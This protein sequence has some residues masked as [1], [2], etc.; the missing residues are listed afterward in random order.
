MSTDPQLAHCTICKTTNSPI[1]RRNESD[2]VVCLECYTHKRSDN[3]SLPGSSGGETSSTTT[4]P[5]KK[6]NAKRSKVERVGRSSNSPL[7]N[8]VSKINYRGRRSMSKDIVSV[9]DW[10]RSSNLLICFFF[11]ANKSASTRA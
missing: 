5:R 3:S 10:P 9:E 1:W 6:K 11:I 2:A 8:F 7:V 4:V